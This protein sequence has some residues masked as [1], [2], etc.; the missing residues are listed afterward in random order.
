MDASY[1]FRT[2]ARWTTGRNGEVQGDSF[3][4]TIEFSAPPQF[5]G[6]TGAWTP[7]HFLLA[8]VSAC[9]ITTFRAIAELSKFAAESLEVRVEGWVEK[10]DNGLRFTRIVLKPTLG[11]V[12]ESELER[13]IRL[14]EKA[15]R[16]C[17][18]SRSLRSE[19]RMEPQVEILVA[20]HSPAA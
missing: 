19:V 5:Q 1:S 11:V 12:S 8:A 18:I 13:A 20:A 15:G 10:A 7:E 6:E 4:P 16:S 17:L 3:A 2:Q 14:L 9:F